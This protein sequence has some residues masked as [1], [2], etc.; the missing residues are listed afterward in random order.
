MGNKKILKEN[1]G[2]HKEAFPFESEKPATYWR[3][4]KAEFDV[5]CYVCEKWIEPGD[6]VF[7]SGSIL[8]IHR[9]CAVL[10]GD[11]Q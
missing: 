3:P 11:N 7:T 4:E 2:P 9:A 6:S 5:I 1:N 10:P 8:Y